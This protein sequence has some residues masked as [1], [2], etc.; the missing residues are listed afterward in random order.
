M[1]NEIGFYQPAMTVFF[2]W[3]APISV[4]RNNVFANC[5]LHLFFVACINMVF[6]TVMFA[7][8][9]LFSTVEHPTIPNFHYW[10]NYL[11]LLHIVGFALILLM[12]YMGNYANL[13]KLSKYGCQLLGKPLVHRSLIFE[14]LHKP[15][16]PKTSFP[17]LFMDFLKDTENVIYVFYLIQIHTVA[18]HNC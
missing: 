17:E 8:L 2:S 7:G 13:Y 5:N 1:A 4:W 9:K 12:Q 14:F 18:S 16:E 11:Y 10:E 3:I 6:P 15:S